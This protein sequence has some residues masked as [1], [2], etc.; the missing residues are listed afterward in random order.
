MVRLSKLNLKPA[1]QENVTQREV[2]GGKAAPASNPVSAGSDVYEPGAATWTSDSTRALTLPVVGSSSSPDARQDAILAKLRDTLVRRGLDRPV[3]LPTDDPTPVLERH[4]VR[5]MPPAEI[6]KAITTIDALRSKRLPPA[7]LTEF[8][9]LTQAMNGE[10]LP[11]LGLAA[12][13]SPLLSPEAAKGL[14]KLHYDLLGFLAAA[15]HDLDRRA[16]DFIRSL[17]EATRAARQ[18]LPPLPPFAIT[19]PM[20]V[21]LD[22]GAGHVFVLPAGA[23]LSRAPDG[24]YDIETSGLLVRSGGLTLTA[25]SGKLSLGNDGDAFQ[26]SSV[27]AADAG[28]LASLDGVEGRTDRAG[29]GVISA[30]RAVI[31]TTRSQ[32]V[33]HGAHMTVGTDATA[34]RATSL[35]ISSGTSTAR[36]GASELQIVRHSDGS[37]K[38]TFDAHDLVLD[39]PGGRLSSTGAARLSVDYGADGAISGLSAEGRA[40]AFS[41]R[42]GGALDVT[43]GRLDIEF[44][45]DGA[46]RRSIASAER[47]AYNGEA[48]AHVEG[49]KLELTF[50]GAGQLTTAGGSASTLR[51]E[52][53]GVVVDAG[54]AAASATFDPSGALRTV[55]ARAGTANLS[56]SFGSVTL[57]DG[58]VSLAYDEHGRMNALRGSTGRVE[59]AGVGKL[60]QSARIGFGSTSLGIDVAADGTQTLVFSGKNGALDLSG[61]RLAL[62]SVEQLTVKTDP[63]GAIASIDAQ[64]P[65]KISFE[66]RNGKLGIALANLH[67]HYSKERATLTASFDQAEVAL[68]S[69]G[70][71]AVI[72]G[73]ALEL[74]ERQATLRLD[75]VKLLRTVKDGL[76]MVDVDVTGLEVTLR[77]NDAHKLASGAL[78][79]EQLQG[80]IGA[81]SV[82]VRNTA[83]QQL[84]LET[85]FSE[86]GGAL[87]RVWWQLPEG[88]EIE[89]GGDDFS[90]RLGAHTGAITTGPDGALR[91]QTDGLDGHAVFSG[92]R[93]EVDSQHMDVALVPGRG[94]V[95]NKVSGTR[96][97]V[98]GKDFAVDIDIAALDNLYLRMT[99]ISGLA[100][101]AMIELVPTGP[102]A[103]LSARVTAS[104]HGI[105]VV[106]TFDNLGALEAAATVSTNEVHAWIADPSGRGRISAQF[107]PFKA[108]GSAIEYVAKYRTF[109]G[110][111]MRGAVSRFLATDGIE[112]TRHLSVSPDGT[113]KLSS[114]GSGLYGQLTVLL[115]VGLPMPVGYLLGGAQNDTGDHGSGGFVL[116]LGGAGISKDTRYVGNLFFGLLPGAF[117]DIRQLRGDTTFLG[118]PIG[119]HWTIPATATAGLGFERQS[120]Q[121]TFSASLGAYV[122]PASLLQ[123]LT[124]NVLQEPTVGGGFFGLSYRSRDLSVGLEGVLDLGR[125]M[126]PVS[127]G[128][129]LMFGGRF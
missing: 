14:E 65:G 92:T 68:R 40:L 66:E 37:S 26:L 69:E 73:G 11:A 71:T 12:L 111:R 7:L 18:A 58:V 57:N 77:A 128:V 104:Y 23:R 60:G 79:L 53:R 64:F 100:Q 106:L 117:V 125:D 33:L 54:G 48:K 62:E 56:G 61:H 113:I 99:G 108:E 21:T 43:G 129:R 83:G 105:P 121:S 2:R 86:D 89:I 6:A 15:P 98:S 44:A 109:D 120:E 22:D 123:D 97:G 20:S 59:W 42:K 25:G 24:A 17:G 107:G 13:Q 110:A 76:G 63:A 36:A 30:E 119:H 41:D 9:R 70:L 96:I 114:T 112:L 118:I 90:L 55:S 8:S 80:S 115:P 102:G 75:D 81:V 124:K 28:L 88:G 16:Q 47:A 39:T 45:E 74:G 126:K 3:P 10:E 93:I 72:R 1:T 122:N 87:R 85:A 32:I 84:R 5:K 82:F 91:V 51:I 19:L 4:G 50:N 95:F 29:T 35:V 34:L 116:R 67:G 78:S 127:G 94:L 103:Q 38:L 52:Q 31:D 101:G 27:S 49:G 46:M